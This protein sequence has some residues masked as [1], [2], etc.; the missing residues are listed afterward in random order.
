MD[1]FFQSMP[2]IGNGFTVNT[3]IE[4]VDKLLDADSFLDASQFVIE[5]GGHNYEEKLPVP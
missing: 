4:H 5:H 3:S 1:K 2:P